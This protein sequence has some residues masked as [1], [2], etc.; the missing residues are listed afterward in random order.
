MSTNAMRK[1]WSKKLDAGFYNIYQKSQNPGD[2]AIYH[3][4][5]RLPYTQILI[6]I[7]T[8]IYASTSTVKF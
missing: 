4:S 7:D 3:F 1:K 6:R 2:E 5:Q 8:F